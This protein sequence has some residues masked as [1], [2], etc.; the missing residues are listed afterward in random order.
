MNMEKENLMKTSKSSSL[1]LRIKML[2]LLLGEEKKLTIPAVGYE[3]IQTDLISPLCFAW[4]IVHSETMR[5][6]ANAE[7]C[8]CHWHNACKGEQ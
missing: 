2:I 3:M 5:Q 8:F 4:K 7:R 1:M 6:E